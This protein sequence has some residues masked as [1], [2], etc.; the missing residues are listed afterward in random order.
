MS[1]KIG[2]TFYIEAEELAKCEFCGKIDE[3]R[4]YG[5]NDENIC[6]DCAMKDE[7]TAARKFRERV[8]GPS[9]VKKQ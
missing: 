4:P 9:E 6:F 7:E 2:D 1:K 8:E 3:L 5:P